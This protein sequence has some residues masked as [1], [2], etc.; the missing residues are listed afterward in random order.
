MIRHTSYFRD[1]KPIVHHHARFSRA[2]T[3]TALEGGTRQN[4]YAASAVLTPWSWLKEYNEEEDSWRNL[5]AEI[6]ERLKAG[7]SA[8]SAFDTAD[9]MSCRQNRLAL[10]E[11]PAWM[12]P[13]SL[14]SMV[15]GSHQKWR[16]EIYDLGGVCSRSRH[17]GTYGVFAE[18]APSTHPL[19]E[20]VELGLRG[21]WQLC[22]RDAEFVHCLTTERSLP[23]N[24]WVQR[25]A[26]FVG[27]CKAVAL[28]PA[29]MVTAILS[30]HRVV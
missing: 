9:E 26:R 15:D 14:R 17:Y 29:L 4:V 11:F 16:I 25:L 24:P 12:L 6:D 30:R 13:R 21:I 20:R 1:P 5:F 7:A 22:G 8:G 27:Q 23:S 3:M 10:W 28:L 19:P 2:I 18:F